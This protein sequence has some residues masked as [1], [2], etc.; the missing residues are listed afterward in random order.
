MPIMTK[1]RDNMPAILIGLAILFVAMIVFEW[2][3]DFTNRRGGQ[4][5]SSAVGKVNG[6]EISYQQFE[7][8]LQNMVDQYKSNSKQDPDDQ[9]MEQ[10]RDQVWQSLVNQILIE[11]AAKKLGIVVTDQEV[12]DWVTSDPESLPDIIKKNF[13][14]STGQ[15]NRQILQAALSSDRP[16]VQQFWK[17]VQD[18]LRE[19][20]LQEK[21]ASR[22]YSA[23]RIPEGRFADAI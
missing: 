18:Y 9:T 19:Q 7:N 1:M 16:E 15:V 3:M 23:L 5:V 4:Y 22:L 20:R 8:V 10:F 11:Q 21:I 17:S 2:G 6:Q 13:E 14:D 12:V